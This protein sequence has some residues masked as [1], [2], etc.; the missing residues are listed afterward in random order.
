IPF[1]IDLGYPGVRVPEYRFGSFD[2]P[3]LMSDLTGPG[4]PQLPRAPGW[5]H[6]LFARPLNRQA[7]AMTGIPFVHVIGWGQR[8][9]GRSIRLFAA[10]SMSPGD[11]LGRFETISLG[12]AQ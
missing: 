9:R 7:V 12:L 10:P 2:R 1:C 11:R 4:M 6:R 5:Y 3:E 8:L